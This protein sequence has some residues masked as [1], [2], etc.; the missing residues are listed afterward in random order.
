MTSEPSPNDKATAETILSIHRWTDSLLTF[1]TTKPPGYRFVAGQFARLGLVAQDSLVW[2]AYSMTSAPGQDNLEF[3]SI[4]VPGGLFTTVLN[5]L[6]PGDRIWLEKQ[7]FGF[8]TVDRFTGGDDLWMFATGT[9]IGPFIS[10]MRDNAVWRRFRNLILV[11][12]VRHTSEFAYRD[13]LRS[14]RECAGMGSPSDARLHVIGVTSR[15]TPA[16]GGS[17]ELHGRITTLLEDGILERQTGI[18]L[19]PDASRVMM[20]GN[21]A[22]IDDM[23]ALLHRRN[24]RPV[25]RATLGHFLTENYW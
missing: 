11:H 6:K 4:I 9:G 7:S 15:D 24:M 16:S 17:A 10:I 25:R 23:R 1:T 21:P 8:M 2:R 3:Y 22:M 18:Q 13:D 5:D 19:S 14:L 20:C 12:G